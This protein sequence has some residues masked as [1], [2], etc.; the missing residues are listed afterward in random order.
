MISEHPFMNCKNSTKS[1]ITLELHR[2][3]NNDEWIPV[4]LED[5]SKVEQNNWSQEGEDECY[6]QE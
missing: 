6:E 5:C 1:H 4:K 3:D 2:K